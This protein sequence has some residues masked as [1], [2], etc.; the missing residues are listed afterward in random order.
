[1]KDKFIRDQFYTLSW[2]E[3]VGRSKIYREN[4]DESKRQ[5]IKNFVKNFIDKNII[6]T[7]TK[8]LM[9]KHTIKI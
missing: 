1:M 4:I 6:S 7:T 5:E 8:L 3:A 9:T 2:S